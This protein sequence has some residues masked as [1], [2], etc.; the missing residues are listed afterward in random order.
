MTRTRHG[1]PGFAPRLLRRVQAPPIGAG[2]H[3]PAGHCASVL[4]AL[5]NRNS[6]DESGLVALDTLDEAAT[7][8]RHVVDQ[9]GLIEPQAI[10]VDQVYKIGRASCRERV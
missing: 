2:A 5:E 1:R 7:A 4:A 6:G 10:E 9:L 3:E 8:R